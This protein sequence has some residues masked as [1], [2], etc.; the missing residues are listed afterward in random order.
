[1]VSNGEDAK[2]LWSIGTPS[3]C[4][5]PIAVK[6]GTLDVEVIVR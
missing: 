4:A 6:Q 3:R 2:V 5:A 1:M